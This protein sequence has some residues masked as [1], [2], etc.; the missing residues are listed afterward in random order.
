MQGLVAIIM[1]VYLQYLLT[2]ESAVPCGAIFMSFWISQLSVIWSPGLWAV[3]TTKEFSGF[4]C[5]VPFSILL[6]S[7]ISPSSAI[8]L[9]PRQ[10]NYRLPDWP[11]GTNL[12]YASLFPDTLGSATGET[13]DV[14]GH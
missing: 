1:A 2:H 14:P 7:I 13:S 3:V 5:L 4:V 12:T 6:V 10:I 11:L 8:A 9:L